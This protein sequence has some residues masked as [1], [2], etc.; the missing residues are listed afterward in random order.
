MIVDLHAHYP[1][2]IAASV[3]ADGANTL[4]HMT[5]L[6]RPT[7]GDRVRAGIL[8]VASRWFNYRNPDAGPAVTV[9]SLRAGG[10]GVV[11]SVLYCPFSEMDLTKPY[12]ARPDS[13]YFADLLDLLEHV[14]EDVAASAA[15][16]LIVRSPVEMDEALAAKKLAVVHAVEGGFHLGGTVEEIDRNVTTL[17]DRGV[18]Y[19]TVAHLFFRAI[20]TNA[21]ALPFVGDGTYK[22]LFPEPDSGLTD[23]GRAMIRAMARERILVDVTHMSARSMDETFAL[24]DT[25]DPS[26][27]IPVIASHIA[28]R[29]GH[30]EYNLDNEHIRHIAE[31]GGVMGILLCA[32]YACDGVLGGGSKTFAQSIDVIVRHIDRIQAL[33][34]SFDHVAIGSDLDGF[35]KPTLHGL[36]DGARLAELEKAL[37]AHYGPEVAAKI[38]HQNALTLLRRYWRGQVPVPEARAS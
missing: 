31:R 20:A 29:F 9:E 35:I 11:L 14:E 30:L 10:V 18:A 28:C 25:I 24:L 23:L 4:G 36:D 37:Q 22:F 7:L 3:R 17:A 33:T 2:H 1:M 5:H 16:A 32:H 27:S 8:W 26:R 12:S 38:C 19:I 21:P 15:D 13:G 6:R 34:G